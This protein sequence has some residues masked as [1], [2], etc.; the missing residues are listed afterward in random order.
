MKYIFFDFEGM[1][2][3]M[4]IC[5]DGYALRQVTTI[6][7]ETLVSCRDNVLAEGTVDAL[8]NCELITKIYFE[9]VWTHSTEA[10]RQMWNKEKEKYTVGQS[11]LGAIKYFYP[12]GAIIDIGSMQGCCDIG[13]DKSIQFFGQKI[14]GTIY[15]FDNQNMWILLN[16]CKLEEQ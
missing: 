4:E 11:V 15:G 13:S 6:E 12:Q 14:S 9:E 2:S 10:L 1:Q 5:D 16:N 3:W 7:G 8:E